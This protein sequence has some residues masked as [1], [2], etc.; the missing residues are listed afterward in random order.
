MPA[1]GRTKTESIHSRRLFRGLGV[2]LGLTLIVVLPAHAGFLDLSW[3][4]PTTNTDGTHLSDL[5]GYRVYYGTSSP[6]ACPGPTFV[7]VPSPTLSPSAGH[8]ITHRLKG[9]KNKAMH[10]VQVTAVDTDGNES[11]CSRIASAVASPDG[12]GSSDG[13]ATGGGTPGGDSSGG[14]TTG[15]GS[16]GG[17]SP[18]GASSGGVSSGGGGGGGCFIATAAYGSPLA[19]QV[20][21]LRDFR[22]RHLLPF[23]VG[24]TLVRLYYLLSP[25]FANIIAGSDTFRAI[26][27]VGLLPI[28][29][30]AALVLWSP[31][32]G[33]AT[34]LL[35]VGLVLWPTFRV[36]RNLPESPRKTD[37]GT[38]PL[39]LTLWLGD[40]VHLFHFF[41][42]ASPVWFRFGQIR[43]FR[44]D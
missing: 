20:Q 6:P 27:R 4:A 23:P 13:G 1:T 41:A 14:V 44:L 22:D 32:L 5:A 26:V 19:P 18:G 40:I 37:R 21:L 8:V 35:T 16:S 38:V 15:G 3:D 28:L 43:I 42:K 31:S 36:L 24:R 12:G 7:S 10:F 39:T 34:L 30:W 29:A 2:I 33:L 17:G 25:P 11:I 9:L